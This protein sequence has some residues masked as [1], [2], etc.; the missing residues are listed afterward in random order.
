MDICNNLDEFKQFT[1]HLCYFANKIMD[2]KK[3]IV[4]QEFDMC[5]GA[6]FQT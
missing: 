6:V 4:S 3:G 5:L 1:V 2:L